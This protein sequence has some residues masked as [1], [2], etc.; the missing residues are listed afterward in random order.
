MSK[1]CKTFWVIFMFLTI[2]IRINAESLQESYKLTGDS[3]KS[4]EYCI[5]YSVNGSEKEYRN[6]EIPI[7]ESDSNCISEFLEKDLCPD[8]SLTSLI[9]VYAGISADCIMIT[10]RKVIL[11]YSSG[12]WTENF[13]GGKKIIHNPDRSME[14]PDKTS[15]AISRDKITVRYRICYTTHPGHYPDSVCYIYDN[16]TN[17]GIEQ[18]GSSLLK[19]IVSF[20]SRK[21]TADKKLAAL[22]EANDNFHPDQNKIEIGEER[23]AVVLFADNPDHTVGFQNTG[24]VWSTV[25]NNSSQTSTTKKY[26]IS[27]LVSE[28]A[29]FHP[30]EHHWLTGDTF[31]N[32]VPVPPEEEF[33]LFHLAAN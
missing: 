13:A 8:K 23:T 18:I 22:V 4:I 15:K 2:S 9:A 12:I 6:T 20:L 19:K 17:T 32:N 10:G 5:S 24:L 27:S 25:N 33:T 1:T 7:I 31:S 14:I 28:Y 29:E 30:V 26:R 16:Y 11:Q 3:V 21:Q